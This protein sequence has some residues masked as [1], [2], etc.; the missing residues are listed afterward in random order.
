MKVSLDGCM[1]TKGEEKQP[2]VSLQMLLKTSKLSV[3]SGK[4]MKIK[5]VGSEKE[6]PYG[7]KDKERAA[8]PPRATPTF[9]TLLPLGG[10]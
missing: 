6:T 8:E 10:R 3:F 2:A 7:G 9:G 1:K 4:L 5:V